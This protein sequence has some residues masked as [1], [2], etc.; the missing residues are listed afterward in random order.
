MV[1]T[2]ALI[3][4]WHSKSI[5]QFNALATRGPGDDS[6]VVE[7]PRELEDNPDESGWR[8]LPNAAWGHRA[9]QAWLCHCFDPQYCCDSVVVYVPIGAEVSGTEY[10][11]KLKGVSWIVLPDDTSSDAINTWEKQF[12]DASVVVLRHWI[13]MDPQPNTP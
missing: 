2:L 12:P 1:C 8:V 13:A 5:R 3:G 7:F 4:N 9:F 10:V 11:A 6:W